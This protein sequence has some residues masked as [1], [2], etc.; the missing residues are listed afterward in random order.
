MGERAPL[1]RDR[2]AEAR[3]SQARR[4]HTMTAASSWSCRRRAATGLLLLTVAIG[5][6][7]AQ[8]GGDLHYAYDDLN[9]LIAVVNASGDV[10]TYEYDAVGN[11]LAIRRVNAAEFPGAVA[12]TLVS[13]NAGRPGTTVSIFGKGFS[14]TPARNIM[15]F[16]GAPALVSAATAT[17][18]ATSVP[19][20]AT[21]GPIAVTTPLGTATS[22]TPFQVIGSITLSPPGAVVLVGTRGGKAE[23]CKLIWDHEDIPGKGTDCDPSAP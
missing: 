16:N 7:V 23:P 4:G 20:G 11:L 2:V 18:I 3:G 5:H 19:D 21:T 1:M 8:A 15:S 17:M 22:A 13:P 6:A 9:R 14:P 12:I 10:S